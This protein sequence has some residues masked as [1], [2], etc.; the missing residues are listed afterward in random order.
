[1]RV[2]SR[3]LWV[4]LVAGVLTLLGCRPMPRA[5][6]VVL[7]GPEIE[8]LDPHVLTGQADGR[9][10]GALFEGLTRFD[11]VSGRGIPGLAER[12]DISLDGRRYTFH[13]RTNAAFST[14]EPI[15]AEDFVWSWRHAV[16][17]STAADYSGFF[18]YVKGGKELVNGTSTNLASLGIHALDPL[19]VEIELVNPTPFFVDLCA[20]RIMAVV[21]RWTV[22]RFGDQWVRAEPL[23]CS[24][25]FELAAWLPNDRVRVRKNPH[26]WDAASVRPEVVD[27]LSSD[28]P[29]TSLNFYLTGEV[30]VLI[31]KNLIPLELND[32]LLKRPDFHTF[33]YLGT[34]FMRFNVTRKPFNDVRVRRAM[35]LVLDKW[36]IVDRITK[37]GTAH[38]RRHPAGHGRLFAASGPGSEPLCRHQRRRS[39]GGLRGQ[40]RRGQTPPG[41]GRLS[42]GS[43]IP[44]LH[45]HVQRRRRRWIP[46]PREDR[47]RVPGDA[48]GT[49]RHPDGAP[50]RRVEDLPLRDVPPQLRR[51]PRIMGGGLPGPHYVP[52]LLPRGQRQQ[53]DGMEERPL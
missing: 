18:F 50:P 37:L 8:T 32:V 35:S 22:E 7:N 44:D 5:D 6:L 11:P 47:R 51:H 30:D 27:F 33:S 17:P 39:G 13:L 25:A 14:G 24:G 40:R 1:M 23:P 52:R 28:S 12:W 43:R 41:R 3:V 20:M 19:T 16:D 10:S 21:P 26:Y 15:R 46:D 42:G 2:L 29:S 49:P 48:P 4:T 31:E 45:L 38:E 36:R 9:V 34:Y 53:P